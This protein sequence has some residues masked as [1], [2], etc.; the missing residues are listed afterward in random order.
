MNDR[1]Y[2]VYAYLRLDGTPCYV[3]KGKGARWKHRGRYGRNKH[4]LH[5][6]AQAKREGLALPC[7]KLAEGLTE[8]EA[9]QVERDL[10]LLVGR[11]E[12][13]GPLV[14]L[15]DGGD[16]TSGRKPTQ[17]EIEANRKAHLGR[18]LTPECKAA[19]SSA[20][21]G[22]EKSPS[23]RENAAAARRGTFNRSGWWSTTEGR[24][25]HAAKNPGHSGHRHSEETKR[26]IRFA[27]LSAHARKVVIT[28][29]SWAENNSVRYLSAA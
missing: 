29:P 27:T 17:S 19:I 28:S 25:K 16:G 18:K 26:A 4:F 24:A 14:N 13:G 6:H 7:I 11:T 3:G 22:K 1:S 20:L 10:I 9:M 8:P 12:N 21:R 15:T 2:Y 5:I 23:H